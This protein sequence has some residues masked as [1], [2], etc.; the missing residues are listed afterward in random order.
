MTSSSAT[1]VSV[2]RVRACTLHRTTNV[3]IRIRVLHCAITH[4]LAQR[5]FGLRRIHHREVVN[6]S[7]GNSER[8][9]CQ[10]DS[11]RRKRAVQ[12]EMSER[13]QIRNRRHNSLQPRRG[14]E[15]DSQKQQVCG[16][17]VTPITVRTVFLCNLGSVPTCRDTCPISTPAPT[18]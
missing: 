8:Y 5:R 13:L 6:T 1:V 7:G 11:T 4:A 14:M 10:R 9:V 12:K 2:H 15:R 16:N 18:K 3:W 17:V